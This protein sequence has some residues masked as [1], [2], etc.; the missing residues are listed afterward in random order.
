MKL[1]HLLQDGEFSRIGQTHCPD[2]IP[3]FTRYGCAPFALATLP[4][5]VEPKAFPMTGNDCPGLEDHQGG[6]PFR[7]QKDSQ[8]L[9]LAKNQNAL[10]CP[11]FLVQ[12]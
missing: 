6:S 2:A 9:T 10:T 12:S 3:D 8:T 11:P 1:L 5:P 4:G 7:P